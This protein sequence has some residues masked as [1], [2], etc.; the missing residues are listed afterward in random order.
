MNPLF[1]M[2]AGLGLFASGLNR[3]LVDKSDKSEKSK[4]VGTKLDT[5]TKI[6][7]KLNPEPELKP[8]SINSNPET[9]EEETKSNEPESDSNS[10]SD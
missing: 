6:V 3:L 4:K 8:N 2:A 1:L 9:P 7:P 10:D 5:N